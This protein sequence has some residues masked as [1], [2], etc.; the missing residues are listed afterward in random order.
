MKF[1]LE[2]FDIQ[3]MSYPEVGQVEKEINQMN[4]VWQLK[5]DWDKQRDMW[6]DVKFYEL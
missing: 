3:A 4:E 6:K 1:G 2:I 5:A